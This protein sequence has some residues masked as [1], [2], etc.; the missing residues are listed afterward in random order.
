MSDIPN[1]ATFEN[2]QSLIALVSNPTEAAKRLRELQA[3]LVKIA[4]AQVKLDA[5]TRKHAAA[6]EAFAK[7]KDRVDALERDL[8]GTRAEVGRLT[9]QLAEANTRNFMARNPSP[10]SR[11]ERIG[12]T[13]LTRTVFEEPERVRDAHYS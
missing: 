1:T 3:T 6:V 9:T 11:T 10:P 12:P 13:G 2:V 7:E 4:E 8:K 5:E